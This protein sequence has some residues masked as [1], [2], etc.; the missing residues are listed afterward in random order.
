[1]QRKSRKHS[2]SKRAAKRRA[3]VA[4]AKKASQ[5]SSRSRQARRRRRE[6][7]AGLIA[8]MPADQRHAGLAPELA[9]EQLRLFM[10]VGRSVGLDRRTR[11]SLKRD[12]DAVLTCLRCRELGSEEVAA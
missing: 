8:K 7:L 10:G 11:R 3:R 4:R 9:Q 1:M 5:G 2:A 6:A 12:V